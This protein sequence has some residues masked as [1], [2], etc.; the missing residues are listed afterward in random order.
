MLGNLDIV[1]VILIG[2]G[3]VIVASVFLKSDK[4]NKS[5]PIPPPV[6]PPSVTKS[7][8]KE[9][10]DFMCLVT[11]WYDL[12]SCAQKQGL[13]NVCSVLDS[14]VFP[15]LNEAEKPTVPLPPSN[16]H[17]EVKS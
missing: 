8:D 4:V 12:K 17:H 5:T 14:Q 2:L 10:E 11:Y 1:Q 15:L 3:I 9:H 13:H 16:I 7:V 6:M